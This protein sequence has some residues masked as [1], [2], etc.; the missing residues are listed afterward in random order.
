VFIRRTQEF[1]V[2][3]RI[4]TSEIERFDMAPPPPSPPQVANEILLP[5]G[6]FKLYCWKVRN[7]SIVRTGERIALAVEKQFV[8]DSVEASSKS[9]HKR[10]TRRKRHAPVTEGE[11]TP[12]STASSND[13]TQTAAATTP[14]SE[15]VDKVPIIAN[16]DGVIS[17]GNKG[18]NQRVIGYIEAC[19]HPTVVDGLCA[20]CGKSIKSF[21]EAGDNKV[22]DPN[23]TQEARSN[24]TVG[25]LTVSVSE[26]EGQ[27][28]AQEDT[29]RLQKE[30]KLSLV[31]DLDH[32]LVHAT[33]DIRARHHLNRADVRSLI[34]PM[35]EEQ[36]IQQAWM[37]HFVKIRPYVK[38]FLESVQPFYEIGVY[39][40]GTRFYAEHVAMMLARHLVGATHDHKDLDHMHRQLA[41]MEEELRRHSEK[42]GS[43]DNAGN[44]GIEDAS[45]DEP[46]FKRQKCENTSANGE[47][48]TLH[49]EEDYVCISHTEGVT[50][51]ESIAEIGDN[52]SIEALDEANEDVSEKKRKRV[53][54]GRLPESV[55]TDIVSPSEVEDFRQKLK[56]VMALEASADE[57][58]MRMFGRR[59]V[60]RNE[61]GDLGRDVKSLK[62]IFPCGGT[63]A[64]V[65]DDR[66]DVW[67]NAADTIAHRP[68][69]PPENMLLVRPYHWT[70]FLGFADVNNAS[71]DDMLGED[72]NGS[73]GDMETDEQL[74]WTADI[75]K[76]IHHR[77]YSDGG[78]KHKQWNSVA[79]VVKDIRSEVL[80]GTNLVL[81]G[82]VPLHRQD[83]DDKSRPRPAIVRYVEQLG[84]T[85]SSTV[86]PDITHVVAAKDGTDKILQARRLPDCVVVRVSWLMECFWTL[87]RRNE[88]DHLLASTV[89]QA[90][91][92]SNQVLQV[93]PPTSS[94]DNSSNESEDD[95][96]D[97]DFAADLEN[98]VMA[99]AKE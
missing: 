44:D 31:L 73:N 5:E 27:R 35:F 99:S 62:R 26:S 86:T 67:A 75:L 56:D 94:R 58:R 40:A 70:P 96:D 55:K 89:K 8:S 13:T 37:E 7:G 63:M 54:F 10:P 48:T 69:E 11:V 14:K 64:V 32:T 42:E 18:T 95:D 3:V 53:T 47:S 49:S 68:G 6:D 87:T 78:S 39:T 97:D 72:Q 76:R 25:G 41:E 23:D 45:S 71:G 66:E 24:M 93:M 12:T 50:L 84:A 38:E 52:G 20:V 61:V 33:N 29:A 4:D 91:P 17:I 30:K 65:V 59:I 85:L 43:S 74:L 28:I 51:P 15:S 90:P 1:P 21:K 57:L 98:E 46:P 9:Q 36:S 77:Y 34:L 16:A 83:R 60:S 82:L 19:N 80:S 88:S 22:D 79:D 81:S 2:R 92:G